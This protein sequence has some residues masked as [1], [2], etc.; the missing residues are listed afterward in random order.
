MSLEAGE[1]K[2]ALPGN[3]MTAVYLATTLPV[4]TL[5]KFPALCNKN[6][7]FSRSSSVALFDEL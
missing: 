6:E 4:C 1:I 7:E 3:M 2:Q 5:E